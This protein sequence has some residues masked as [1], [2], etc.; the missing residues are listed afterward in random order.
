MDPRLKICAFNHASIWFGDVVWTGQSTRHI[1]AAFEQAGLTQAQARQILAAISPGSYMAQYASALRE[2]LVVHAT[3]DLTFLEEF[4]QDAIRTMR[5][6]GADVLDRTLPC[7]HYTTGET[8]YKFID[9]W[10][11]GKFIHDA[12]KRLAYANLRKP[13]GA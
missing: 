3:Y 1:R 10:Y 7:G 12:Y 2:T 5:A 13:A 8:P 6:H 9:A 11:L 4:S